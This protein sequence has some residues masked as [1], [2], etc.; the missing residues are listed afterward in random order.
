[1]SLT[2][3]ILSML[4]P[5]FLSGS[6]LAEGNKPYGLGICEYYY[7]PMLEVFI[8]QEFP[9]QEGD[10][11]GTKSN[12]AKI[13]IIAW[14]RDILQESGIK[15]VILYENGELYASKDFDTKYGEEAI[16][17]L[18]AQHY[19]NMYPLVNYEVK[20]V[21]KSGS[22]LGQDFSIRYN[23]ESYF[24]NSPDVWVEVDG[25][26]ESIMY[27][28]ETNDTINFVAESG[29]AEVDIFCS[30]GFA[31]ND[32]SENKGIKRMECFEDGKFIG[33]REINYYG[34]EAQLWPIK[35]PGAY[36]LAIDYEVRCIDQGDNVEVADF[37]IDFG[38]DPKNYK[39]GSPFLDFYV[40]TTSPSGITS[41]WESSSL[42]VDNELVD[43]TAFASNLKEADILIEASDRG[44]PYSGLV[45]MIVYEN[46]KEIYS[47]EPEKF[48]LEKKNITLKVSHDSGMYHYRAVVEDIGGN[49]VEDEFNVVFGV[50]CD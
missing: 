29:Q 16:F 32:K 12:Q 35:L 19:D 7:P 42:Y 49:V 24:D 27:N 15:K 13:D 10:E 17:S 26:L 5:L 41:E 30:D 33:L 2:K 9:V 8:D 47:W 22:K 31:L 44:H 36:G 18:V 25:K 37:R 14:D 45:K 23:V 38:A 43:A 48:A 3:R 50:K 1:M 34:T 21:D 39:D 20:A 11:Y 4:V 6:A 46:D 40:Q 28:Q